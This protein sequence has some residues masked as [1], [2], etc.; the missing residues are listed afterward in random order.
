MPTV[1]TAA[2]D[3]LTTS[4][5]LLVVGAFKGGI[6]A[7][8]VAAVLD[9]LGLEEVPST[10]AFR[11][12]A[13]QR[14]RLAAPGLPVGSVLFVGLGRMDAVD[15][16]G[17]RRAAG[18][19]AREAWGMPGVER[20]VTTLAHLH[21]RASSVAALAEGFVLGGHVERRFRQPRPGEADLSGTELLV[22]VPSSLAAAAQRAAERGVV[23]AEAAV[24]ARELV[25]LPP[26]RKRPPEL[27]TRLAALCSPGCEVTVRDA[28]WLAA[29]G[30]GALAAVGRGSA[31][32]P[33]L[34]ELRYRPAEPTGAVTLVGKGITF[35]TGGISLKRGE[36]MA[37][38]K[39]DMAGAAAVAAACSALADL[40]VGVEV[41]ALLGLAENAIGAD[42]QRPGDVVTARDGQT[43]EVLDTD[44]EG[45]LVLADLLAYAAEARPEA[46]VDVATLTGTAVAAL[47]SY[48]S[49]LF[50]PDDDLAEGLAQAAAAT[51]EAQWRLPLWGDLERFLDSDVADVANIGDEP[52]GGAIVAALFLQRFTGGLPWA[53]LDIAGPALLSEELARDHLPVGATGVATRTLLAWLEGR[54]P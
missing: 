6:A 36:A 9:A 18:I 54:S 30:F 53:H 47:G 34:V 25:D 43:I 52:G 15:G 26:D 1:R 13:G 3:P 16:E 17:L 20:V 7:P 12:E 48:A 35:D 46:I 28:D 11:G 40:G 14:L 23:Y 27:A 49:A 32:P 22:L 24:R 4:G 37:G 2:A 50:S 21:P 38:M 5:D 8:G 42:A 39:A 41:T 19:A 29:E 31:A 10:S 44:A 51:G 33:R 45:R